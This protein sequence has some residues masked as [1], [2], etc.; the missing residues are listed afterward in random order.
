ME[1]L[2]FSMPHS[3]AMLYY[4]GMKELAPPNVNLRKLLERETQAS[5]PILIIISPGV[6]P[7]QEIEELAKETIGSDKYHQ[8]G[9]FN[10]FYKTVSCVLY[11]SFTGL[12]FNYHL[13]ILNPCNVWSSP[14]C[15]THNSILYT[16]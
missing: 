5:E 13:G 3:I 1:L 16:M 9:N 8:V 12:L 4:T 2:L 15:F 7:S 11:S 14:I 10:H 6:D